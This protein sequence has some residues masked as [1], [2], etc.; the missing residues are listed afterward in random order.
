[1]GDPLPI[2]GEDTTLPNA[3]KLLE[4]FNAILISKKGTGKISGIITR[5][6]LIKKI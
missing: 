3:Q 2:I 4:V 1:M 6:D 5:S